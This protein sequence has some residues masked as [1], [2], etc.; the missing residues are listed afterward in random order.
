[1]KRPLHVWTLFGLCLLVVVPA[2]VWLT[3]Q[4]LAL[5]RARESD[6]LQTELA[7]QE[8]ELQERISSALW[9][10]DWMLT[11][12]V[13]QE[14]ARPYFL[15]RPFY[16]I[17]ILNPEQKASPKSTEFAIVEQPSPLLIPT[18]D[19]VLL[20]FQISPHNEISS[21]QVPTELQQDAALICGL[22]P[23]MVGSN[24]QRLDEAAA[25]CDFDK[26]FAECS[27]LKLPSSHQELA[28]ATSSP[29]GA[30]AAPQANDLPLTQNS[31]FIDNDNR[32]VVE[33]IETFLNTS[34]QLAG[35]P[36]QT[37]KEDL[38]RARSTARG[39][40]ESVQRRK[41]TDAYAQGQWNTYNGVQ[42]LNAVDTPESPSE[43]RE[44]IMRPV[45]IQGHLVLARRVKIAQ[46]EVV[47]C[48]WLDWEK[49]Q[50]A[51]RAEVADLLPNVELHPVHLTDNVSLAKTLATLPVEVVVDT[52]QLL[53]SLQFQKGPVLA[54]HKRSGLKLALLIAWGGLGI[55]AIAG[56]LLLSGVVKLSER[57]GAF[58]S[59]VTHELR[60]P[61]TTFRMYAEM[62]AEDMVP[63][64]KKREYAQTLHKE[65]ERLSHLVENVLQFARLEQ[66]RSGMRQ[67]KITLSLL[68]ERIGQRLENRAKEADM[69]FVT[70]MSEDVSDLEWTTDPTTVEQILFNLV[71]NA[72]KYAKRADDRRICLK[73]ERTK[74]TLRLKVQDFG[75]GLLQK[76]RAQLFRAFCKSDQDAANT[77]QGVGLGLALCQRMAKSLGGKISLADQA[78]GATFVLDLPI[79]LENRLD[80]E[81]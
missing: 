80:T 38:Q 60:T 21:P 57:R 29:Q 22:S 34:Q 49:I 52:Q 27:P 18:S 79:S 56:G 5:D 15:Y 51:L 65:S 47:Q 43:V 48:C 78:C 14:A 33:Q 46:H 62:L 44:G 1:M 32:Q 36:T 13:A 12:L 2:M 10:M 41:A 28:F 19:F 68:L 35:D 31:N 74:R 72:C 59:A 17:R 25:F 54:T 30:L 4:T 63:D 9:R 61:L 70:E 64:E 45:W 39:N 37:K 26:V 3:L 55:A 81:V 50:Q 40:R 75:P 20:N 73:A 67:Q 24:Q 11:P 23:T 8:A 6:R 76:D 16:E 7:R 58:V 66:N 77:E 53:A 42:A 69:I 71:D